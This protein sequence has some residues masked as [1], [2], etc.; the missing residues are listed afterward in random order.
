MATDLDAV[1]ATF[2][3]RDELA[4]LNHA[5][6][7]PISPPAA[8]ALRRYADQFERRA[9]V[10]AG[11]YATLEHGRQQVAALLNARGPH[12]IAYVPNTAT[13]LGL[14]AKGL[15]WRAGDTVVITGVEYPANRYPWEDLTHTHGVRLIE[16]PERPDGRIPAER[17]ADAIRDDTRVVAISAVQYASGFR[18]DLAAISETVR[19]A[20]SSKS[21]CYLC[22]DA[23]QQLGVVPMDVRAMGI[24]FL[25][26]DGHKWLL[27]PEGAGLFYCH[28]DLI[29]RLRPTVVGAMSMVNPL[30]FDDYAFR[31]QDTAKRFEPGSLN[32]PGLVALAASVDLL[33]DVGIENIWHRVEQLT[34]HLAAGLKAKGWGVFSPRTSGGER[35]GIVSFTPPADSPFARGEHPAGQP[36]VSSPGANASDLNRVVAELKRDG[37]IL[38]HRA[39][40]L[41]A[42]PHFHNTPHHLDR[43][44]DA[45]P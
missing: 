32:V 33:L 30:A 39:G 10:D 27:A 8:D 35:S 19:A 18:A 34:A 31:F 36:R 11:W 28:E 43:L 6:V 13:G 20:S 24:D 44:L 9:Y 7:A 40:R 23:I 37:I 29:E 26:A 41:R 3:I 16:V 17:I 22:V 4:F 2:P 25:A 42:S 5:G 15:D 21:P 38:A 1:A 12:E 14:V 45:L